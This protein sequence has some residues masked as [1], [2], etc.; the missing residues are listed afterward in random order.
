M[1]EQQNDRESGRESQADSPV[2]REPEAGLEPMN[3][4]IM[5]LAKTE[6]ETLNQ[7]SPSGTSIVLLSFIINIYWYPFCRFLQSM[8]LFLL[9]YAP[10]AYICQPCAKSPGYATTLIWHIL[11]FFSFCLNVTLSLCQTAH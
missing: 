6:S 8:S 5:I 10:N 3:S 4:S 2:S 7:R 1:R 9:P 11:L